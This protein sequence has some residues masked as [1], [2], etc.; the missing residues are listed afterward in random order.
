M[1]QGEG[2]ESG[3]VWGSELGCGW[4]GKPRSGQATRSRLI[5]SDSVCAVTVQ[6]AAPTPFA[7]GCRLLPF[8][9]ASCQERSGDRDARCNPGT[10]LDLRLPELR[11]E[12]ERGVQREGPKVAFR[13]RRCAQDAGAR[14]DRRLGVR[15]PAHR[16][17]TSESSWRCTN[18]GS[19]GVPDSLARRGRGPNHCG[20]GRRV[21]RSPATSPER[22]SPR[23]RSR[24]TRP[25]LG[26]RAPVGGWG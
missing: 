20:L 15:H 7:A 14:R 24:T 18:W 1:W 13:H 4:A 10:R 16:L 6:D 12:R 9:A 17:P 11:V 2:A 25:S 3:C 19:T 26:A 23:C 22:L 8:P 5:Q 21:V